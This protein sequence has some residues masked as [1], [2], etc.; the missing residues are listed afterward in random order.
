MATVK[1]TV[2]LI[3]TPGRLLD[4]KRLAREMNM[5]VRR[6]EPRT[7]QCQWFFHEGERKWH[8]TEVFADSEALLQHL[9]DVSAQL[10]E[11]LEIS[12]ISRFEVFGE[13]SHAARAVIASFGVKYFTLWDGVS[14]ELTI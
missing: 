1:F 5:I 4:F 6:D 3:V 10:E 8:L 13:L 2:E 7:L 11:L 12:E 9:W 14:R